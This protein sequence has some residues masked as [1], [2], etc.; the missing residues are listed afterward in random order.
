MNGA[1]KR[2]STFIEIA[3]GVSKKTWDSFTPAQKREYYRNHPRTL[4]VPNDKNNFMRTRFQK[5]RHYLFRAK[6]S[7]KARVRWRVSDNHTEKEMKNVR[8]YITKGLGTVGITSDG[9]IISVCSNR[10]GVDSGS[11]LLKFAIK[12]GGRKLD[13]YGEDLYNFYLKN[14]FEPISWTPFNPKY[15][16]HDWKPNFNKLHHIIFIATIQTPQ[17]RLI[18]NLLKIQSLVWEKMVI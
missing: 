18:D 8:M 1:I 4:Y 12:H 10:N 15:A 2:L 17:N 6:R 16:P 13:A 9:D 3:R 5:F 14:G 11:R 7:Q